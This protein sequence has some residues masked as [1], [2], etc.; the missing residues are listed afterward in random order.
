MYYFQPAPAAVGLASL[1]WGSMATADAIFILCIALFFGLLSNILAR[2]TRVPAT[3][4]LL[5]GPPA[6]LL[7]WKAQSASKTP[8][9]LLLQLF[10]LLL[11]V[12]YD[13]YIGSW[14]YVAPGMAIW[15]VSLTTRLMLG[16]QSPLQAVSSSPSTQFCWAV[17]PLRFWAF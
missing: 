8:L 3:V 5:V 11:G 17:S 2:L 1:C 12:G 14:Q 7:L 6:L 4:L 9:G 16:S 10:G 13:F 15:Q